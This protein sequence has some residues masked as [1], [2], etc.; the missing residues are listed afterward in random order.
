MDGNSTGYVGPTRSASF[1]T[2]VTDVLTW[3]AADGLPVAVLAPRY[4][5]MENRVSLLSSM[6]EGT[7]V[8]PDSRL[9]T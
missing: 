3:F 2:E 6:A 5:Q 8:D 7:G 9:V 1:P 4:A